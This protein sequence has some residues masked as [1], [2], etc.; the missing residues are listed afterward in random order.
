MR[1]SLIAASCLA[2]SLLASPVK[3]QSNPQ[4]AAPST[5]GMSSAVSDLSDQKL[6]A[7]AAA[8]EEVARLERDYRDQIE[9]APQADRQRILDE[10]Q[11]VITKAVTD[12]GLSV[13]EYGTIIRVAANDP[14]L[15]Q[16]ILQRLPSAK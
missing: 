9:A 5:S 12:R 8:L 4:T 2:V 15:R 7:V 13:E 10:A 3:A 6:D 16:K 11:T 1:G 14:D